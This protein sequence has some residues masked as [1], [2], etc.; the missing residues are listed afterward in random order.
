MEFILLRSALLVLAIFIAGCT[1]G[2]VTFTG[3]TATLRLFNAQTKSPLVRFVVDSIIVQENIG[4]GELSNPIQVNSGNYHSF[5]VRS[6][7]TSISKAKLAFQRYVLADNQ[8]YTLP[9]RGSTITDYSKVIIDTAK[10]PFDGFSA[11]KIINMC[12]DVSVAMVIDGKVER[13]VDL[14]TTA[15]FSKVSSTSGSLII[16]DE[17]EQQIGDSMNLSN[18]LPDKCYYIFVFDSI[19]SGKKSQKY[20]LKQM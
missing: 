5:E 19:V 4:I 3:G 18:F 8:S 13:F 11:V 15:S 6:Y 9:V 2:V 14:Q 1:E 16:R 17:F 10:S 20:F 12:E 7:D